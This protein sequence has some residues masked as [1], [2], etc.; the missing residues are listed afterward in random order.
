MT[1]VRE[2]FTQAFSDANI[3]IGS[4]VDI[5]IMAYEEST[6]SRLDDTQKIGSLSAKELA[7]IDQH[8]ANAVRVFKNAIQKVSEKG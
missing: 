6:A 3:N 2:Y 4:Q 5:V 1:T 8:L 7:A